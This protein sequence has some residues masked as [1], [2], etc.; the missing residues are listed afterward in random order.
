MATHIREQTCSLTPLPSTQSSPSPFISFNPY[1]SPFSSPKPSISSPWD[2]QPHHSTSSSHR[3]LASIQKRF[4]KITALAISDA[5]YLYV[6]SESLSIRVWNHPNLQESSKLRSSHGSIGAI[7]VSSEDGLIFSSHSDYKVRMWEGPFHIRKGTFPSLKDRLVEK[8][9]SRPMAAL[10]SNPIDKLKHTGTI[11]SLAY[12][13]LAKLLYSASSDK[14]VKVWSVCDMKCVE[15]IR[16][17]NDNVNAVAVGPDELLFTGSDD[18]TVKI[19]R[20][21][22]GGSYH[23]VLLLKLHLQSCAVKALAVSREGED[24]YILYAGCSSGHVKYW[25]KGEL[26]GHM[27]YCGTLRGHNQAV[28]CLAAVDKM[29]IS[30]SADT[31]IRVWKRSSDGLALHR[32]VAVLEGHVAPVKGVAAKMEN[33]HGCVVYSGALDGSTKKWLVMVAYG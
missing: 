30:G 2:I 6:G 27:S 11:T 8:C 12:N 33:E 22:L 15:T 26:S 13:S 21:S 5:G 18:S 9:F 1:A 31:R 17:H 3:C 16:A 29:V 24:G 32:C 14:T 23:H 10:T 19:W 25:V 4:G 7:V 28:L 20:R